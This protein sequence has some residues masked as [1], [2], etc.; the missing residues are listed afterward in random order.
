[1]K[2]LPGV[3]DGTRSGPSGKNLLRLHDLFRRTSKIVFVFSSPASD[4]DLDGLQAVIFH[5]Q[6][7]LSMDFPETVLLEAIA[8]AS[9]SMRDGNIAMLIAGYF[10]AHL[11]A[12]LAFRRMRGDEM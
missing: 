1:M 5:L 2:A 11:N 8:H 4:L 3:A 7:K 10:G 9:A 12:V 6:A